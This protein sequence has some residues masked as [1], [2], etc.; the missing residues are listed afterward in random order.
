MMFLEEL[1]REDNVWN[2]MRKFHI[3]D[4]SGTIRKDDEEESASRSQKMSD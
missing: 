4:S 3:Q 2:V 1:S